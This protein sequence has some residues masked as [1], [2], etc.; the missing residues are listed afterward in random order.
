MDPQDPQDPD[1]QGP[2]GP[3][4]SVMTKDLQQWWALRKKALAN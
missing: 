1:P 4:L 2:Q 3:Q